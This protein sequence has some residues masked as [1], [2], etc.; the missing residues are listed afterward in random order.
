MYAVFKLGGTQHRA[1]VGDMLRV[2]KLDGEVGQTLE[3]EE[4]LLIGKGEESLVGSPHVS[5]A[6]ITAEIVDQGR[7]KKVLVQKFKRRRKYR[8]KMGHRQHFT[9]IRITDVVVPQ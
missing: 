6:R 3:I 1:S 2:E 4:V 8:R 5:G 7:H 9:Q